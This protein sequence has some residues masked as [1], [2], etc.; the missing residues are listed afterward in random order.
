M[1]TK[2]TQTRTKQQ[3]DSESWKL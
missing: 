3:W 1:S 2:N